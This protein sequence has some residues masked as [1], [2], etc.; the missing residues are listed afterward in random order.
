MYLQIL[1]KDLKRKKTMNVILFIF[2]TLAATFIASSANNMISVMTA[3]DDY[4]EM[5]EVPDYWFNTVEKEEVE[6]FETFAKEND[7]DYNYGELAQIDPKNIKI[8][9]ETMDY[10]NTVLVSKV[11][12]STKIFDSNDKEITKVK[13]GEIYVTAERFYSNENEFEIGKEITF[14]VNGK[15]KIFTVKDCTKDIMFGS[16]MA[17]STRF[18]ISDNDYQF[19]SG[20]ETSKYYSVNMYTDDEDYKDKIADLD[21]NQISQIYKE[22]IK[23][24]YI[25]DMLIAAIL[26]IVSVCLILISMIILR[27][28]IQF[29]LSEEFR[30]IGVMK[31]IGIGNAKIRGLYIVKYFAISLVGAV[32]GFFLSVPFG[33]M[34]MESVSR[35]IV[36][37]NESRVF[38]NGI[39]AIAT[40]AIV[41][42]FCYLCTR[43]IKKFSPIDAIRNGETGERFAKKS[44]L[45]LHKSHF[46]PIPFMAVNDIFS[47]IKRFI[48]MIII[49]VLGLLLIIIPI[50]TINTLQSAKLISWF[51]MAHCDHV[52]GQETLFNAESNNKKVIQDRLD[53][54]EDVF[55]EHSIEADVFQEVLFRMSISYG[56]KK[57]SSLAFQGMGD[58]T[59]KQYTYMEG[60]APQSTNEV[61]IT[62]KI[63]E[64]IGANIGDEVNIKNGETEKKYMVTAIYQSMNN[65]G[66]GIRFHEDAEL[67]YSYVFGC[68]GLQIKY[69]DNPN[70]KTFAERTDLLEKEF[71]DAKIYDA[72]SYINEMIGDIAGQLQS[73]K[74]LI[75]IVVLCINMLVTVLMVRS[76]IT[77]EKGQIAMLKSIGFS[78]GSLVKWQTLR[79]GVILLLSTIIATLLSTPLSQ[80]CVGPVFQMMGAYT[81]E[82][83]VKPLEV[84]VMYPLVVFCVTCLSGMFAALRVRKVQTS[85]LSIME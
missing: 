31:A 69:K 68:F 50:N 20:D 26:L 16:A 48:T 23:L 1:K 11:E 44:A 40:A 5:A 6:R 49:F 55:S 13:D 34:M 18:L 61:A 2:I 35:N 27:F 80:A 32:I 12:G 4:M 71:K 60:T 74:Q 84:Y 24:V 29:T 58:V 67:D 76:F 81:I 22:T 14:T 15:K 42:G 66:E 45:S 3:L 41:V 64:N 73:V 9:G 37:A 75:L 46:S 38:L 56:N 77:K 53:E 8:N 36:I 79:I 52:I 70:S 59:T 65:M 33:E 28:T 83:E 25:M 17:G 63:A 82:F 85:D 78:D 54:V 39:C 30:E 62:K 7:Y 21:L 57:S 51:N 19:F 72:G 47:Q 43:K 10:A